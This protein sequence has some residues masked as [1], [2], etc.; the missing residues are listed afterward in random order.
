MSSQSGEAAHGYYNAKVQSFFDIWGG[1]NIHFGIFRT[2]N[3]TLAEASMNTIKEMYSMVQTSIEPGGSALELGSGFGGAARYLSNRGHQVTCVDASAEN[4]AVNARLNE[5]RG[6]SAITIVEGRFEALDLPD[7]S[8]DLAWSQEAICH[9]TSVTDVFRET[10]R[11]LRPGGIFALGNT[12]CTDSVPEATLAELNRRNTLDLRTIEFQSQ[13][14]ESMG[15]EVTTCH[16]MSGHL[17]PHYKKMIEE[18]REKETLLV[19]RYGDK[20]FKR[21]VESLEYWLKICYEGNLA[22]GIWQFSKPHQ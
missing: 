6:V 20:Q 18:V 14:A 21:I 15:F 17:S 3:E 16:D 1:E 5:E 2:G 12:C 22:W 11:V 13:L 10:F 19:E 9:S 4:N 7:A 8:F